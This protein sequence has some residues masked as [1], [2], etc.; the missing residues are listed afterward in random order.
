[1]RTKKIAAIISLFLAAVICVTGCSSKGSDS[2]ESDHAESDVEE[3]DTGEINSEDII[4]DESIPDESMLI[5]SWC[6]EYSKET[7]F[8][9]NSDHT[10]T[11]DSEE[12]KYW[13]LLD[14]G[15]LKIFRGNEL[16]MCDTSLLAEGKLVVKMSYGDWTLIKEN[17]GNTDEGTAD[18][19]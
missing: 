10:V 9:L 17:Q 7:V 5:G 18:Q 15:F 3:N 1:M 13:T 19:I 8:T 2:V 12:T 11:D 16:K 14:D 4:S 6:T